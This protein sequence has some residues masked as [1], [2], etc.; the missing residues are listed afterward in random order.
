L[1]TQKVTIPS[2]ET[3]SESN[4]IRQSN[5]TAKATI[6]DENKISILRYKVSNDIPVFSSGRTSGYLALE[7]N[8]LVIKSKQDARS[9]ALALPIS[10]DNNQWQTKWDNSS[11][12]LIFQG[13]RFKLGSYLDLG[14]GGTSHDQVM[15]SSKACSKYGIFAAFNIDVIS[16]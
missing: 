5:E 10:D 11:Q 4:N 2:V 7:N 14:G 15:G 13:E 8:C 1:K 6:E 12:E 9:V 3:N 16:S